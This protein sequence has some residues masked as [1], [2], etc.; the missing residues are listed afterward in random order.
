MKFI[1]FNGSPAGRNSATHK[2]GEALL[3]GAKRAGAEVEHVYLAEKKIDYCRGCFSCWFKTP[4]RCVI[5]D[6]MESL[7]KKYMSADVVCFATPVF[8]WNMTANLKAFV[9]RLAPLKSPSIIQ[10]NRDFDLADAQVKNQNFVVIANCGFP[11]NNNFET[12][13]AVMASCS[14]ILEIYRNCGKLLKS[15][16]K[17]IQ[18]AVKPYLEIVER[19]GYELA[20]SGQ[21]SEETQTGLTMELMSAEEYIRFLGM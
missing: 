18:A 6:D 9:D 2:I 16:D 19:A 4:G 15:K 8:T 3:S 11:G 20:E 5:R 7:I 12:L 14:P 17:A 13:K 21:V 10:Q 1:I